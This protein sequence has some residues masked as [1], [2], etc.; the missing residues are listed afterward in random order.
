[1][2]SKKHGKNTSK[3]EVLN[4]S[5]G[6]LWLLV[7]KKEYFLSYKEHP[8]FKDARVSE[9]YNVM[10]LHSCHLHWKDLDVDLELEALENPRDYPL[11]YRLAA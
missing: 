11:K 10:L 8:W 4:I 7:N 6:G 9:I 2:K 3:V 5:Q 1:M